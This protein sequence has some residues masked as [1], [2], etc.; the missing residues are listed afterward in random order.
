M[1][2]KGATI[3]HTLNIQKNRN[4]LL[5]LIKCN[6]A[7]DQARRRR[8]DPADRFIPG[9]IDRGGESQRIAIYRVRLGDCHSH[10]S[11]CGISSVHDASLAVDFSISTRNMTTYTRKDKRSKRFSIGDDLSS[12]S[13]PHGPLPRTPARARRRGRSQGRGLFSRSTPDVGKVRGGGSIAAKS[14]L[15]W[16]ESAQFAFLRL[17][18][19]KVRFSVAMPITE[20]NR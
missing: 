5:L 3:S 8:G 4:S 20:R 6:H 9:L 1:F 10:P 14:N 17:D 15:A 19:Q 7:R 13:R 11:K 2:N 16:D 12:P 18:P